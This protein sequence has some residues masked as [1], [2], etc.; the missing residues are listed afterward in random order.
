MQ[1]NLT[2]LLNVEQM[3]RSLYPLRALRDEYGLTIETAMQDDVNGIS[4][5]YAQT[6]S[7]P[8]AI[9][10]GLYWFIFAEVMKVMIAAGSVRTLRTVFSR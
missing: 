3:H 7:L 10:L 4:W 8:L 6:H 9:K 5:L 2:P 1:Y